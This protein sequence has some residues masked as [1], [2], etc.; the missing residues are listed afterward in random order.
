M[1][2]DLA[3]RLTPDEADRQSAPEFSARRL[4]ANAAIEA[5]PQDI[6]LGLAHRTL[7][8]EQEPVVK[9]RWVIRAHILIPCDRLQTALLNCRKSRSQILAT[10]CTDAALSWSLS[11]GPCAPGAMCAWLMATASSCGSPSRPQT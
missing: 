8:A 4:V 11:H 5:R 6:K 9:I 2:P 7:E 3:I 10:R 1:E